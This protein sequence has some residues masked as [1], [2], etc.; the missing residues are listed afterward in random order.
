M[1]PIR[2]PGTM[3]ILWVAALLFLA[4]FI[5]YP[6][7]R[8]LS[9]A[10]ASD[11]AAVIRSRRF[12][13][14]A[15]HSFLLAILSTF[16][17]VT[18][19]FLYAFAVVR[20]GLPFRRFFAFLP[21]LHLVTPP[22]VGGLS[23]ILLFG[24]QGFVTKTL[25]GLDVSLYGLPGLLIAQTLCFFPLAYLIIRNS[26]E[27]NMVTLENAARSLGAKTWRRFKTVTFPLSLPG[28]VFAALLIAISALSDFGNPMLIGGRYSVLAVELYT[29][30]T[31]WA[32]TGKSAVLGMV[33]LVPSVGLFAVQRVLLRDQEKKLSM[34][35]KFTKSMDAP[36][37]PIP[38]RI[39]LFLFAAF[40]AL[41][42]LAQFF[43][44]LAGA[45]SKTWGVDNR[46]TAAHFKTVFAY[47][48]ELSNTLVFSLLAALL[49]AALAALV[50]FAVA[51]TSFPFRRIA[52]AAA[53][54][55]AAI[56]GTFLGLA[57]V[58][59]FSG[60]PLLT[61]NALIII[62]VMAVYELPAAVRVTGS[63]LSPLPGTFDDSA[64]SLGADNFTV[65]RTVIGPLISR[66]ILSAFILAFV[67]ATGTLSA[68]IFLMSF[69]TKLTSALILN[70]A[71]QGNWG[72]S[73]A[74]ALI[75]TLVI[76]ASLGILFLLTSR[77]SP[78]KAKP[79]D[80]D[81]E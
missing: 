51:R 43:A 60:N 32:E 19:G 24:R 14:A 76:F 30:L 7:A 77:R 33:L 80:T 55:P 9:Q 81:S 5:V 79:H 10:A 45:F 29:Q 6:L 70:L 22:F 35:A 2:A 54:L 41:I 20:G 72:E 75:L 37:L 74:L 25:L 64:R 23:F 65:F 40:I 36:P 48:T 58:I 28:I 63:A 16:F 78:K 1:K 68:V 15:G 34:S 38:V 26:L 8:A 42:V 67:R 12:V 59:A 57:Y 46:F 71:A 4:A 31:G 53:T 73:A 27:S 44:V 3:T 11:W 17:A 39:A 47:K 66:G 50:S 62:L 13:E 49:T 61:G 52:D 21:I 69:T 56:P 18:T